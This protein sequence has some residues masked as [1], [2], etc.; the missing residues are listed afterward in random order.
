MWIE[1]L[2]QVLISIIILIYTIQFFLHKKKSSIP[3]FLPKETIYDPTIKTPLQNIYLLMFTFDPF[4]GETCCR[5]MWYSFRYVNQDGR[6]GKMGKWTTLPVYAGAKILPCAPSNNGC[7]E[8]RCTL[9]GGRSGYC[10]PTGYNSC[11]CNRP[12]LG[13]VDDLDYPVNKGEWYAVLHR[14][15]DTFDPESQGIPVGFLIGNQN[16]QMGGKYSW[17]DVAFSNGLENNCTC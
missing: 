7:K 8:T 3:S 11:K 16:P 13:V 9:P 1:I 5:K 10:V 12:V 14:Q 17:P 6:F 15:L 2:T 4:A